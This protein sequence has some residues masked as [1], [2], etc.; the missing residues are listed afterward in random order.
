MLAR[1]RRGCSEDAEAV[2]GRKELKSS[3]LLRWVGCGGG[4]RN[5]TCEY[6]EAVRGRKGIER[7]SLVG[8]GRL[9]RRR[10]REV[11]MGWGG[12]AVRMK[13][14]RCIGRVGNRG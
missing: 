10:R 4:E 14:S 8:M 11:V 12:K 7:W 9:W 13:S 5:E 6:G 2:R 3:G 1:I